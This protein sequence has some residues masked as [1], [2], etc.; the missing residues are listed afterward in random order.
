M[1][2]VMFPQTLG[3]FKTQAEDGVIDAFLLVLCGWPL[4]GPQATFRGQ[5]KE[6]LSSG[7]EI[8]LLPLFL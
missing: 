2:W 3:I 4:P 1:L 7:W 8:V 5:H 6:P